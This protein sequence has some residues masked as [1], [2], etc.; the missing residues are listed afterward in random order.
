MADVVNVPQRPKMEEYDDDR[1]LIVTQMAHLREHRGMEVE[2][3]SLI[4]GPGWVLTFQE[5]P[6]DVF[7]P[8]RERVRGGVGPIRRM[9]HDYL[10]SAL[11]SA[12][13]DAYFPVVEAVGEEIDRLEEE[14]MERPTPS[15]AHQIHEI[16]RMLMSLHR[17]QWRQRD[18]L[19][20]MLHGEPSPFTAEVRVYLR[21]VYDHSVQVLDVIET[22]RDLVVGLMDIYL[23]AISNRT[24][25]VMKAL[26]IMASIFIPLTFIVGVYGMN[27]EY[28]P[29]LHW[30]WAYHAV[31]GTMI[32][33]VVGLLLWFRSRGW[34]GGRDGR[35]HTD[36]G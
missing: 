31:W 25:E 18:A 5:R 16:R 33:I 3:L 20:S 28:M 23:S 15:T 27:F 30:K 29:E 9:G 2:Q 4:L 32:A 11:L 24:N 22:S 26:T 36:G 7:E 12:I 34:I 8:I 35:S 1:H 21:D 13:V 17:I 10:A 19:S 6:G 14:V